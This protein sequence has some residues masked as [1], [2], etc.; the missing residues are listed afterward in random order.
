[1]RRDGGVGGSYRLSSV[2][3]KDRQEDQPRD[4]TGE[5]VGGAYFLMGFLTS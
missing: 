3:S 1:M 5:Q 2:R 4:G